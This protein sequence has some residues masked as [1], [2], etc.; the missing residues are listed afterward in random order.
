[1]A[2]ELR[3]LN[4]ERKDQTKE[5]VQRVLEQVDAQHSTDRVLVVYDAQIHESIAGIVAGRVREAKYRP[6]IVL[7][8]G[9]NGVKGSGRSI[10]G[11]D[12]FEAL[13]DFRSLYQGFGGHPMA[14]GLSLVAENVALLREGLNQ[15]FPL[16]DEALLPVVTLDLKLPLRFATGSFVQELQLME[17]FGKA[18]PVPVFVD[19]A[20]VFI[21]AK[22][23]GKH[24]NVLLLSILDDRGEAFKGVL[25]QYDHTFDRY[26]DE[27]FGP[28]TMNALTGSKESS[29]SMDIVYQPQ[30]NEFQDR[31]S[32]QLVIKE[33]R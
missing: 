32:I 6:T 4:E 30:I 8:E 13:S 3:S 1:L 21:G 28:G 25:F 27:K 24:A 2:E 16:S 18:N 33:Y 17:P 23:V 10:E 5:G 22:I 9:E 29:F 11:Y 14:I 20:V 19:Q 31:R 26:M 12:M 15:R 7:T